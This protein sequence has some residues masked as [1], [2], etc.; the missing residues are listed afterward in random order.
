MTNQI[1][2][3]SPFAGESNYSPKKPEAEPENISIRTMQEDML[4][5]KKTAGQAG[6]G[7]ENKAPVTPQPIYASPT[8][9]SYAEPGKSAP[10]TPAPFAESPLQAENIIEVPVPEKNPNKVTYKI[11]LITIIVLVIAIAGL[12]VYYFWITRTPAQQPIV[13]TPAETQNTTAEQQEEATVPVKKYSADNPNYLSLDINNLFSEDIKKALVSV[14]NELQSEDMGQQ[15]YEFIVTDANNN[16]IAFPIFA[17]AAKLNLSSAVLNNLGE[18]FYLFFY[19]DGGNMRLAIT[20]EATNKT[21]LSAE[22]EKQEKTFIA[23][24]SFLFLDAK[25]EI[26]T[27]TFQ[28]NTEK[29]DILIRFINVN[30]QKNL[31][32]DYAVFNNQFVIATSRNTMSAVLNKL[33]AEKNISTAP[34]TSGPEKTEGEMLSP[35]E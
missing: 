20:T 1:D 10:E 12:G 5:L 19:N 30:K 29:P 25:P 3:P 21:V 13:E 11:I 7:A 2:S 6:F 22:L 27:G 8:Q 34:S 16:P 33:T 4:A 24:A 18:K 28:S 17:L 23:D 35:V 15:P 26:T 14:S 32:I 31:S 9:K